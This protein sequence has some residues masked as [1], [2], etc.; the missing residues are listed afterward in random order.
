MRLARRYRYD[1]PLAPAVPNHAN[2]ASA[3]VSRRQKDLGTDAQDA[4]QHR[5]PAVGL[6]GQTRQ[7]PTS[8]GALIAHSSG[9]TLVALTTLSN[10]QWALV[11]L[12]C[13]STTA[14]CIAQLVEVNHKGLPVQEFDHLP[15]GC[16][17]E[18]DA[19]RW[20]RA[21]VARR[22][23]AHCRNGG[24]WSCCRGRDRRTAGCGSGLRAVAHRCLYRRI[25]CLIAAI[26]DHGE[27]FPAWGQN[28][29]KPSIRVLQ[30]I[31]LGHSNSLTSRNGNS[32]T[33]EAPHTRKV[34]ERV[35]REAMSPSSYGGHRQAWPRLACQ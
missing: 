23:P 20:C 35:E 33:A 28:G 11:N 5:L 13:I 3:P 30:R 2:R 19:P 4:G 27:R 34:V 29:A 8:C 12:R 1:E 16:P 9:E 15:R 21:E 31:Q 22:A 24:W 7:F 17:E 6:I 10:N 32:S 14:T 18:S 25:P 26:K